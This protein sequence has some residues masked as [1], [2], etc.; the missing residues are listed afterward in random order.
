MQL[1]D[2]ILATL[3]QF[4]IQIKGEGVLIGETEQLW[5]SLQN[6]RLPRAWQHA[7]YE[8]AIKPLSHYLSDLITRT[9]Y[10]NDLITKQLNARSFFISALYDPRKFLVAHLMDYS[11]EHKL[12]LQN[13]KTVYKVTKFLDYKRA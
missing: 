6:N 12:A 4:L 11:R 13:L 2:V 1:R 9:D 3:D 5:L 10:L 8:T 7:S